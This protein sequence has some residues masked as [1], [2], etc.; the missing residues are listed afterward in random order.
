MSTNFSAD[1]SEGYP[2]V[3]NGTYKP[4]LELYENWVTLH[5]EMLILK[6]GYYVNAY[7]YPYFIQMRQYL[8]SD[9]KAYYDSFKNAG[10]S[11]AGTTD[12]PRIF[13]YQDYEKFA[14]GLDWLKTCYTSVCIGPSENFGGDDITSTAALS[15]LV[16]FVNND[17]QL[18]LFHD[19]FSAFEDAGSTQLTATLRE[20]AGADKYHVDTDTA[21]TTYAYTKYTTTDT[22]KYPSSIY[23]TTNLTNDSSDSKYSGYAAY[24]KDALNNPWFSTNYQYTVTG[25]TDTYLTARTDDN[26]K[27]KD[28]VIYSADVY[29]YAEMNWG[30]AATWNFSAATTKANTTYATDRATKNNDAIVTMF[31]FS[32]ADEMYIGGT[33]PQ[34]LALDI[35][36]DEVTVLYSLAGG[37]SAHNQTSILAA[38]PGDGTD[39]YFIYYRKNIFYCGAGHGKITGMQKDNLNERYLYMNIICNSVRQSAIAPTISVYD[40]KSTDKKLTNDIVKKQEDGTYE[41]TIDDDAKYPSFSFKVGVD[42]KGVLTKVDVYYD[43]DYGKLIPETDENGEVVTNKDGSVSKVPNTSDDYD[44]ESDRLIASWSLEGNAN[45]DFVAEQLGHI[46]DDVADT[47]HSAATSGAKHDSSGNLETYTVKNLLTGKDDKLTSLYLR[48]GDTTT[49]GSAEPDYFSPYNGNYTYIVI[50]ATSRVTL[51]DGSVKT[52]ITYKRIKILRKDH[53]FNLT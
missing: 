28:N 3:A 38:D 40:D 45:T 2:G 11:D 14:A 31:P 6:G 16:K 47:K 22:E 9:D 26:N 5:D 19:T 46:C 50:K 32:L 42:E 29:E 34:A 33:H 21:D 44:P 17:G 18:V 35:D 8:E 1:L 23:F 37:T 48:T 53:L 36:D 25:L 49:Y 10:L 4:Y 52:R 41:M 24:V 7:T 51:D 27:I 12:C 30:E 39:N 20:L 43:L 15:A 13:G